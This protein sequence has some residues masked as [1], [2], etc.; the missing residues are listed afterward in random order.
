MCPLSGGSSLGSPEPST[1]GGVGSGIEA[2]RGVHR[3]SGQERGPCLCEK[4]A[5][6]EGMGPSPP[7]G[8]FRVVAICES[9]VA[10][11]RIPMGVRLLRVLVGSAEV[12]L[13]N[14]DRAF[15]HLMK[16][17]ELMDGQPL[18]ND[19]E[20]GMLLQ[21]GLTELWLAKGDLGE[22]PPGGAGFLEV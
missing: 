22:A 10:S 8:F 13:G 7:L 3:A 15:E 4:P 20:N 18:M 1:L 9:I 19:W 11:V 17:K 5:C 12:A 14:H 16:T 21:A 6:F 2:S